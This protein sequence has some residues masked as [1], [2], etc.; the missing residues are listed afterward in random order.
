MALL[1]VRNLTVRYG[2]ERA[3]DDVS[4]DVEEGE[5]VALVGE[6]GSGK[7]TTALAIPRLLPAAAVIEQGAIRFEG[8]NIARASER[9]MRALRGARIAT[10]FQDP[11]A[12][13]GPWLTVGEQLAEVRAHHGG[14]SAREARGRSAAALAE[15]GIAE[16]ERRLDAYPHE[17]SGGMRQR[18]T[19]AMALLLEPALLVC[20]EPTS[21]LDAT[22]QVQILDL[23]RRLQSAHKTAILLVTHSL[24]VVAA[25]ADRA[26]VLQAGRVVEAAPVR[27]LFRSPREAYTR[28]LLAAVPGGS[29]R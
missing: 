19:I 11:A 14:A 8:R 12:S 18:A 5:T 10:V 15:V 16:P 23:L 13:L 7:S 4:L 3:V 2:S 22:L 27:Q 29:R 20:D 9:A 26:V 17:L 24:G 25:A 28:E 1:E 21:A 6:S